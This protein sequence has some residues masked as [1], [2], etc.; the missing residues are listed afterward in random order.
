MITIED[1]GASSR[2]DHRSDRLL[3]T[4]VVKIVGGNFTRVFREVVASAG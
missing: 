2:G 4:D 3:E 1:N